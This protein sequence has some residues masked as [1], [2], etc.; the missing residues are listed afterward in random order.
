[1]TATAERMLEEIRTL[2]PPD[3][4]VVWQE[5]NNLVVKLEPPPR[6]TPAPKH[7][8]QEVMDALDRLTGCTAGSN[9]L[10][11]LLED[12][13]RDRDREEAELQ[14]YLA[15]RQDSAHE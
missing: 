14:A 5:I 2:P 7:S 10:Q 6:L 11:R 8:R 12:R 1:M 3:L 15:R 9:S 13:Q 4:R